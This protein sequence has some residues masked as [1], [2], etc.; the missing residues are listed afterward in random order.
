[1]I[2]ME[3]IELKSMNPI[4]H[5]VI[6]HKCYLQTFIYLVF[7]IIQIYSCSELEEIIYIHLVLFLSHEIEPL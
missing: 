5:K 1:M 4:Y 3:F 6:Q 2:V 7:S